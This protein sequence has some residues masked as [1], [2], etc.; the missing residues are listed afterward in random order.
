MKPAADAGGHGID[1]DQEGG[2]RD[3]AGARTRRGRLRRQAEPGP[4]RRHRRLHRRSAPQGPRR[5]PERSA[6]ARHDH[7]GQAGPG[8]AR[9][10]RWRRPA[11]SSPSAPRPAASRPSGRCWRSCRPTV[12]RSSSP[13]TC[14][15]GFTERFAQRLDELSALSVVE[16]ADRMVLEPGHAY[17]APGDFHLRVEK[18]SGPA[19]VPARARTPRSP[20]T[21]RA[22]MSCSNP[23]P[24]SSG[25]WRSAPS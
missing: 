16:A 22:S 25:R 15:A 21:G 12:R 13:S 6:F 7:A 17:V 5:R 20:A 18:T 8:A 23:S 4:R 1:P 9:G 3:D 11:R 10:R 14:R 2:R 24:R 19:Q